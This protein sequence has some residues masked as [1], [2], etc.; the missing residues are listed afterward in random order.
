MAFSTLDKDKDDWPDNC[1]AARGGGGWWFN[2]CSLAN[3]NGRNLGSGQHSYEG[4]LW[5]SYKQDNRSF[6]STRMM[7]RKQSL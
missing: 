7:I 4:I 2:A 5:Y 3:L 6:R 1:S